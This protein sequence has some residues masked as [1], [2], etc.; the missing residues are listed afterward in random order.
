MAKKGAGKHSM[1][2]IADTLNTNGLPV[3]INPFIPFQAE[4]QCLLRKKEMIEIP[5]MRASVG[6]I[7]K[8]WTNRLE[9][10]TFRDR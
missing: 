7:L 6:Q 10:W 9:D 8:I 3:I 2:T 5:L 1:K 4:R